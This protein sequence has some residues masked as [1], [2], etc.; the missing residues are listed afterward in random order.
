M[1]ELISELLFI[2]QRLDWLSVIDLLLVSGI[3]FAILLLLR[4]TQ[5]TVLLR[6]ILFLIVLITLLTSFLRLPAFSWLI[7]VT[8]PALLLAIPV[9]FAP[10]IRR[11]LAS[12]GRASNI[13]LL[14]STE[15]RRRASGGNDDVISS[16]VHACGRLSD[17]RHGALIVLQRLDGLQEYAATGVR[18]ESLLSPE[19]LLQIFYKNTPLHD[20]AVIVSGER[21]QAAACVMPISTSGVLAQSSERAMG[22]RHRA[23]LGASEVSDA[24]A[25][26]VSEENGSI[27]V[28][29]GGR[30][31]QRLDVDRLEGILRT[32]FRPPEPK[33]AWERLWVRVFPILSQRRREVN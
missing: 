25:V 23:A 15:A 28:S 5:A 8:L 24:V 22:L 1:S 30:M 16:I 18:M 29:S 11:A 10:E 26:V 6:G 33:N 17:R 19:L 20:G 2:F 7:Q 27:S 32:F 9:I 4:D 21:I 14:T 3:F 31:I 12:L 13:P